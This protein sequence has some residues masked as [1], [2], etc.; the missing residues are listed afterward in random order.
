M[1]E[2]EIIFLPS[3]YKVSGSK[4]TLFCHTTVPYSAWAVANMARFFKFL[5]TPVSRYGFTSNNFSS[6]FVK[7]TSRVKFFCTVTSLTLGF[8]DAYLRGSVL[9]KNNEL[10]CIGAALHAAGAK[11]I[12][13]SGLHIFHCRWLQP[14]GYKVIDVGFSQR[15]LLAKADI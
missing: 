15:S 3:K 4:S 11:Q 5:N 1:E 6:P 7:V 9:R 8:I 2:S 13:A 12:F 14:T 10:F